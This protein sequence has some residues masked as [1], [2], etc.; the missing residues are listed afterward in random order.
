MS[1]LKNREMSPAP[2]RSKVKELA[3]NVD[4]RASSARHSTGSVAT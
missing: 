4:Q 2:R 1:D 3:K